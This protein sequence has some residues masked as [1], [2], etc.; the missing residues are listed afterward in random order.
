MSL[1]GYLPSSYCFFHTKK[2]IGDNPQELLSPGTKTMGSR[3][4]FCCLERKGV[5][6]RMNEGGWMVATVKKDF[7]KFSL[8][9]G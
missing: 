2:W 4:K 8:S 6:K 7:W 5:M 3:W 1:W 9:H